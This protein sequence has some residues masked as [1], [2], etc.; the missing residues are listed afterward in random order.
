MNGPKGIGMTYHDTHIHGGGPSRRRGLLGMAGLLVM[1][2]CSKMPGSGPSTGGI[3]E[4]GD[5]QAGKLVTPYVL[6][7]V[8][9]ATASRLSGATQAAGVLDTTRL[10]QGHAFGRIGSGDMLKVT[11]WE[12]N[13]N[14]TTLLDH[15][16]LDIAARVGPDGSI[17]LPYVG[18]LRVGG[19][20]PGQV[21][22]DVRGRLASESHGMQA[23]VLVTEDAT[24]A[25]M[26]QGEVARPGRYPITTGGRGLLDVLSL[27]GGARTPNHQ[28]M[29]RV[30]RGNA[31]VTRSLSNIVRDNSFDIALEPGD[32]VLV[33]PREQY[34]YAFGAVSRA[35]EQPY[36]ADEITLSRTLARIS[37]LAENRANPGGVFIYRRQSAELT[38]Q[39][40]VGTPAP[41]QDLTQ[42]VYRFD[43]R[44]PAG[45]F[46]ANNFQVLPSDLLYVSESFI[47][48]AAKILQLIVGFSSIAAIP[49]N[50]GAP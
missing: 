13:P 10:P 43:L 47:S 36:N 22:A 50:L 26:V 30:T 39:V 27:A 2:G 12:P 6:I 9:A 42:V 23:A 38:R 46:V 1:A 25:V 20:T 44:D 7:D 34:F 19:R 15:P 45:F 8:N 11:L 4:G 21:E 29:V 14:G 33:V 28:A 16:G 3:E 35:G 37:G 32:R 41:E 40:M 24:N 18:R 5:S 17:S 48:Q 49:R 31:S